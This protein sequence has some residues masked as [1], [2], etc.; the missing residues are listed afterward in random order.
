METIEEG[1]EDI[2]APSQWGKIA[3][4]DRRIIVD[5]AQ[6][7]T[8]GDFWSAVK[9]LVQMLKDPKVTTIY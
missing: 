4:Q 2:V 9:E 7:I 5:I 3:R 8:E 1:Y 6:S